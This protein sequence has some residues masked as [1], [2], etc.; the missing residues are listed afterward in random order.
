MGRVGRIFEDE[1]RSLSLQPVEKVAVV[2]VD[3]LIDRL[4]GRA[5][6]EVLRG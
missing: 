2:Y 4:A 6:K 1:G 3:W 5:A